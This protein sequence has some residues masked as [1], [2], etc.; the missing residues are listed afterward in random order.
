MLTANIQEAKQEDCMFK[1]SL[2]YIHSKTPI[3]ISEKE[4]YGV[5]RLRV[6]A[7][8]A[9]DPQFRT[10]APRERVSV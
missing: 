5:R 2:D 4:K 9:R 10:S 6:L 8:Q 1:A 3:S 7:G